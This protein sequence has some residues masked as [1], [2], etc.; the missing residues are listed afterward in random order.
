MINYQ[1]NSFKKRVREIFSKKFPSF[2]LSS[3]MPLGNARSHHPTRK[4]QRKEGGGERERKKMA[5]FP[6]STSLV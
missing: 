6:P 3:A 4:M 1:W 5:D 2:F